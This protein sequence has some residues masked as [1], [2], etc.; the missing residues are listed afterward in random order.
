MCPP[1]NVKRKK[2]PHTQ[3]PQYSSLERL[4]LTHRASEALPFLPYV[5]RCV[6]KLRMNTARSQEGDSTAKKRLLRIRIPRLA[7][8]KAR[9]QRK[10][11][12]RVVLKKMY[13]FRDNPLTF[14][15]GFLCLELCLFPRVNATP[16][17]LHQ[18]FAFANCVYKHHTLVNIVIVQGLYLVGFF[19][20]T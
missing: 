2:N 11:W 17:L 1:Q 3:K 13:I 12:I 10:N 20:R 18:Q 9:L 15:E 19:W 5:G 14:C 8:E 7:Q 6:E 4:P 16:Q